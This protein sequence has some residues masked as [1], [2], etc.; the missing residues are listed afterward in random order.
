MSHDELD[1][2]SLRHEAYCRDARELRDAAELAERLYAD[3][4]HPNVLAMRAAVLDAEAKAGDIGRR[5]NADPDY[6]DWAQTTIA[7]ILGVADF[8]SETRPESVDDSRFHLDGDRPPTA[9]ETRRFAIRA[10]QRLRLY[11][12]MDA[13]GQLAD[14]EIRRLCQL[15]GVDPLRPM[16]LNHEAGSN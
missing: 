12:E 1:R 13:P 6:D 8:G 14:G 9:E 5:M 7:Q 2:L 16:P 11:L 3:D 15:C 4:R 10:T